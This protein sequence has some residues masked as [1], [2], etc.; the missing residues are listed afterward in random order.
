MPVSAEITVHFTSNYIGNHTICWRIQGSGDPYT[1]FTVTCL[2]GGNPCQGTFTVTVD[3]ETCDNVVYE[4]YVEADCEGSSPVPFPDYTFV[5]TP[6]CNRFEV[7]CDTVGLA[8]F[9]IGTA[10]AGYDPGN[11]P[12]T[13]NGGITLSGGGGSGV[14]VTAVVNPSAPYEITGFTFTNTG[15][16]YVTAPL[17]VIT[18]SPG[19]SGETPINAVV[20]AILGY[21]PEFLAPDCDG[22]S[23][24]NIP[25]TTFQ[26]TDTFNI[27][28]NTT[29]PPTVP[30]TYSVVANGN[31][32]CDCTYLRLEV[33]GSGAIQYYYNNCDGDFISATMTAV[34]PILQVCIV[35]Q[36]FFYNELGGTP[37]VSATYTACP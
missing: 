11:A 6:T 36:T 8:G 20:T 34:D 21:C 13:A 16:G 25:G 14:I 35:D 23:V 24:V 28:K 33:T 27:C 1:C 32:L 7:T 22:S 9:S 17:V 26:P 30:S 29:T 5:P 15:S 31:C 37:T 10:G 2:G 3:N 19:Y 4:G 18:P 12:S